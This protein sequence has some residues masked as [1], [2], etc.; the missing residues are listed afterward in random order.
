MQKGT[1][2][3]KD[4]VKSNSSSEYLNGEDS[5]DKVIGPKFV[6][7]QDFNSGKVAYQIQQSNNAGNS[8]YKKKYNDN[9]PNSVYKSINGQDAKMYFGQNLD[10]F[11]VSDKFPISG[12][13][14]FAYPKDEFKIYE[15]KD[16][17]TGKVLL[18]SNFENFDDVF[19]HGFSKF[20]IYG[21]WI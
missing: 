9:N 10:K 3:P 6:D 15:I 14:S 12:M 4:N 17:A 16:K 8:Y 2:A 5:Y 18:Y 11:T 1:S 13:P 19:K 20:D 7:A 21:S